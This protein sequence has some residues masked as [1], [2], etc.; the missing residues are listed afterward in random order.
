M[1]VLNMSNGIASFCRPFA[2]GIF[3]SFKALQETPVTFSNKNKNI[4][5]KLATRERKEDKQ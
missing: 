3:S 4:C 1:K 5:E 2:G